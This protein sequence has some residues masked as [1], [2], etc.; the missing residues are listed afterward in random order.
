MDV[1][2]TSPPLGRYVTLG[3][4]GYGDDSFLLVLNID[5]FLELLAAADRLK[6]WAPE[7]PRSLNDRGRLVSTSIGAV[8]F[9][10][11]PGMACVSFVGGGFFTGTGSGCL[12]TGLFLL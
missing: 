4:S 11:E 7:D 12:E 8:P 1:D 6:P 3:S 5:N 2:T 10:D 9:P